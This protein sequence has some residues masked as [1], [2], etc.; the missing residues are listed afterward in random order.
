M[1]PGVAAGL[2]PGGARAPIE[3]AR[4]FSCSQA[5]GIAILPI[6]RLAGT[7]IGVG[8]DGEVARRWTRQGFFS[9][10]NPILKLVH[11]DLLW[12]SFT[13]ILDAIKTNQPALQQVLAGV[14]G[15]I[16]GLLYG[17]QQAR[18]PGW[19]QSVSSIQHA[20]ER[21]QSGFASNLDLPTLHVNWASVIAGCGEHSPNTPA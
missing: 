19:P 1:F 4:C 20:I 11:E 15:E 13:R 7:N 8:F 9:A 16:M 6:R 14:V 10:Q 21:M 5:F 2:Y 12:T 3:R 18:L 17:A